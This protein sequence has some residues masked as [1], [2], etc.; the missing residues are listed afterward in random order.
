MHEVGHI[1]HHHLFY[2]DASDVL[3]S[4]EFEADRWAYNWIMQACNQTG[5]QNAH[6]KRA[7]FIAF[8]LAII[9]CIEFYGPEEVEKITH[10]NPIDRLLRFLNEHAKDQSKPP[11]IYPWLAASTV[12]QMHLTNDET[13]DH[14]KTWPNFSDF[15]AENRGKFQKRLKLDECKEISS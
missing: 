4:A 6:L 2:K 1:V 13:F 11:T 10:P 12:V 8:T 9:G 7:M 14:K 5:D 3:V 15:L